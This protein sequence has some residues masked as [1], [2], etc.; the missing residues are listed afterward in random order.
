MRR[1]ILGRG[2]PEVGELG[3]GCMGMSDF[4]GPTG[5]AESLATIEAA[6]DAGATLLDTG[7]FYGAGHNELLIA[8]A[9]RGRRRENVVLSVKFGTLRA[10][11]GG[12]VGYDCR[13]KAVTAKGESYPVFAM[14]HLD[15]E[16]G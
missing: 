9:L 3:L 2:G 5:R 1:R 14:T 4:Y 16:R 12:W 15:S 10:P 11:S 8:E 7:D 6:L 13:P